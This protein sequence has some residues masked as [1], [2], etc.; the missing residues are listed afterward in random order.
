MYLFSF[1]LL[2]TSEI[3]SFLTCI[4]G[5]F[6]LIAN[7]DSRELYQGTVSLLFTFYAPQ[8]TYSN[9]LSYDHK[10]CPIPSAFFYSFSAL[11]RHLVVVC[12]VSA[13]CLVNDSPSRRHHTFTILQ[14]IKNIFCDSLTDVFNQ[15]RSLSVSLV[16][17]LAKNVFLVTKIA[18]TNSTRT[19][20]AKLAAQFS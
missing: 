3:F 5:Y 19:K 12:T 1:V 2:C 7:T 8:K 11:K 14:V 9:W 16:R 13:H 10:L 4:V 15:I 6:C 18:A 20:E 17:C